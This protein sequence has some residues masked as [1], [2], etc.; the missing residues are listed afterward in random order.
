LSDI[1]TGKVPNLL[2]RY[3]MVAGLLFTL[4][5]Y[6]VPDVLKRILAAALILALLYLF[7][8][9]GTIGAGDIKLLMMIALYVNIGD[10]FKIIIFIMLFAIVMAVYK[11]LKRRCLGARIMYFVSYIRDCIKEKKIM[12]YEDDNLQNRLTIPMAAAIFGGYSIWMIFKIGG[13]L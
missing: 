11:M 1:R 7:Y 8:A 13:L 6:S 10:Y 12:M 2:I 3:G 5:I 4:W 9:I